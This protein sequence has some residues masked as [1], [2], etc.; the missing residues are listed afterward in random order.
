[1]TSPKKLFWLWVMLTVT[2]CQNLPTA[3]PTATA[4]ITPGGPTLTPSPT[5]TP[6]P[7]PTLPPV[8]RIDSGDQALFYGDFDTA[9][10]QYQTAYAESTDPALKAAALWGLGRTELADGNYQNALE[11]FTTLINDYPDSTYSMR[12]PFL[13]GR[14][15]SGLGNHVRA[16]QSYGT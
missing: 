5:I 4:T 14:A 13:M 15:Y 12:A 3:V 1:M 7:L 8:V 16:A 2:A 9:R 10:S 11:R 6:T